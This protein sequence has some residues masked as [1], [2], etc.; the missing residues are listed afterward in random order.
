MQS[1]LE[2]DETHRLLRNKRST[3]LIFV[4][5]LLLAIAVRLFHW[6]APHELRDGDELGYAWGSLQLLEGNLPAIHYAPAGPQT[7]MGWMYAG[8]VSIKHLASPDSTESQAPRQLRP[9]LAI[10]HA[11]FDLYR[12]AASLRQV[13]IATSFVCAM[14]GV[15]AAFGLGLARARLPG[16]I[17]MGGTIALLPL[18]VDFSVQARPYIAA[19]SFGVMAL[20]FRFCFFSSQSRCR[21]GDLH[22]LRCRITH[23]H[24]HIAAS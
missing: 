20:Y 23:R 14:A 17:F 21:F 11:L 24:V 8:L 19:W 7:W 22:G 12:D 10:D 5:L 4:F 1:A 3:H 6:P 16:A 9:F 15:V 18:F 13:W 2:L